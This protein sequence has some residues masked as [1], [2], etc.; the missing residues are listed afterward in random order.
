M[1]SQGAISFGDRANSVQDRM[2]LTTYTRAHGSRAF[3][4]QVSGTPWAEAMTNEQ[5]SP[6]TFPDG[7]DR[8]EDFSAQ[9]ERED[10]SGAVGRAISGALRVITVDDEPLAL[11]RLHHM[12]EEI[13]NVEHV[14]SASGCASALALIERE[15]P[16]LIL[17]DVCMRDGTGFDLLDR[18]PDWLVPTVIFVTGFDIYATNA[19]DVRA[20]DYLLKPFDLARLRL[21]L[22]RARNTLDARQS[23]ERIRELREVVIS[24]REGLQARMPA[25]FEQEFWIRRQGGGYVRI[26][27]HDIDSVV[28]DDDYVKIRTGGREH[29]MRET[30]KGMHARLD[31]L[32]FIRIHRSAVVRIAAVK[33]FRRNHTG[34]LEASMRDG[35]LLPVGRVYAKSLRKVIAAS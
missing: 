14:G 34:G 25:R 12:L 5:F 27:A 1:T 33:E 22:E 8:A 35:T 28:A 31:P 21:A 15:K 26:A 20:V 23:V 9:G 16:D 30:V 4:D 10:S 17:L 32:Q 24:L 2:Q 19:F 13:P 18:L 3:P 6:I 29:L 11:R 7:S